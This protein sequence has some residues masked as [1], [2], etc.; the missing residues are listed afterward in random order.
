M[1]KK[2]YRSSFDK[3]GRSKKIG[4]ASTTLFFKYATRYVD[5]VEHSTP[6]E[7]MQAHI[8]VWIT[9]DGKR[10]PIDLKG[11]KRYSDEGH[12]LV[13]IMNCNGNRGW[14]FGQATYI[15]FQQGDSFFLVNRIKLEARVREL[16]A[17]T[18]LEPSWHGFK[19]DLS[20]T[21]SVTHQPAKAPE[22]Y[23]RSDRPNEVVTYIHK[24]QFEDCI[25]YT[26]QK[27]A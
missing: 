10:I 16:L 26:W 23:T 17:Y 4:D 8:D 25:E 13:E 3:S 7:D 20:K 6:K 1:K 5:K 9:I 18:I 12:F 19:I 24:T 14:L 15:A 2:S 21:K 27:V 11:E 22:V